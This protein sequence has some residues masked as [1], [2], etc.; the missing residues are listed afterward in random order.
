MVIKEDDVWVVR[1]EAPTGK[2]QRYRC[3]TAEQ[4][5]QMAMLL[6]APQNDAAHSAG[7]E[8]A[9]AGGAPGTFAFGNTT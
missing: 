8:A 1:M 4:A 7:E 9:R 2:V 5:R 6:T 3:A